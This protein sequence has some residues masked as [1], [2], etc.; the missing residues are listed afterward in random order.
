VVEVRQELQEWLP[1]LQKSV[2]SLQQDQ[3]VV[4]RWQWLGDQVQA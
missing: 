3:L 1:V 2:P 4:A